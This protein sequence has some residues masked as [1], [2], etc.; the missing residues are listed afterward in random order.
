[1]RQQFQLKTLAYQSDLK[2]RALNVLLY[3]VD[4]SNKELTCF[5]SVKTIAK[6]LHISI[7]TVKRALVELVEKGF[8]KK[9]PRFTETKNGAQTSNLYTLTIPEEKYVQENTFTNN[10]NKKVS[11]NQCTTK[12][13]VE[14]T[15]KLTEKMMGTVETAT[16]EMKYLTFEMI[17]EE[18]KAKKAEKSAKD[19]ATKNVP[20]P[21]PTI[22]HD[23]E[24][25]VTMST[26]S[27]KEVSKFVGTDSEEVQ[28]VVVNE[29]GEIS[30]LE[31]ID[32]DDS[33]QWDLTVHLPATPYSA[34]A[35]RPRPRKKQEDVYT[36]GYTFP[37]KPAIQTIKSEA[38]MTYE[39]LDQKNE[40][41]KREESEL[42]KMVNKVESFVNNLSN[43]SKMNGGLGQFDTAFNLPV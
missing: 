26:E 38:P 5:P 21:I 35:P 31:E 19:V 30:W 29:V 28:D 33:F 32:A 34:L 41:R 20:V 16:Y 43:Q 25:E 39:E 10:E 15:D 13:Q 4:R 9:D 12:E 17:V 11:E 6:C 36:S 42:Q 23:P 24:T 8:V 18:E 22:P 7:S 14:I 3:L 2:S 40:A 1:M 37:Y 27:M